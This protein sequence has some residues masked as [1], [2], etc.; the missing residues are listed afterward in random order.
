M[1]LADEG[2]A[3]LYLSGAYG[4]MA[5]VPGEPG[6]SWA[7]VYYHASASMSVASVGTAYVTSD[8]GYAALTYTFKEPVLGGQ[9]AVSLVGA[10]GRMQDSITSGVS[11]SR[12]GFNDLVPSAALRWNAGVDNYLAYIQGEIPSGTYDSTRLANFGIGH[13]GIDAG[14]GYTYFDS[15]TGYEVSAVA[16][17]TFNFENSHTG[18]RNGIDAH[19]D[20][21]ASRFVSDQAQIGLVG[22]YYQQLTADSGQPAALGDFKSRV[23][24]VGPQVGYLFPIGGMQG[25]LNVKGYAEFAS[26]NRPAGWNAWIVLSISPK[27]S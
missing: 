17:L 25:Y 19:V 14:A 8:L 22:Y 1:A 11:D 16:G 2:G 21:A 18:Y 24:A 13:G 12:Y 27:G 26:Q 20:L 6:W 23:A 5:A 10:A 9:L 3:S 15:R 7:L 4:S